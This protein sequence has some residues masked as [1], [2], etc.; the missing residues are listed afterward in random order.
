MRTTERTRK[1]DLH[2]PIPTVVEN[3]Y[4][5]LGREVHDRV[6][7]LAKQAGRMAAHEVHQAAA[8][9]AG[10]AAAAA[11]GGGGVAAAAGGGGV[12]RVLLMVLVMVLVSVASSQQLLLRPR[13][14]RRDRENDV[15]M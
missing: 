14:P 5:V 1:T 4:L 9:T 6:H 8:P 2:E 12:D 3:R 13:R 7:G 10:P 11:A 15:V